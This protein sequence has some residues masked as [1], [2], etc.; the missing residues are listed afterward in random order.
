[1]TAFARR[2]WASD[3]VAAMLMSAVKDDNVIVRVEVLLSNRS[4]SRCSARGS[5]PDC[6]GTAEGL[7]VCQACVRQL[8]SDGRGDGAAGQQKTPPSLN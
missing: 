2:A 8:I 6:G 1:M 4:R 3:D 5:R 7:V